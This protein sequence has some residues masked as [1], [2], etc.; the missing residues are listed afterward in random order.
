ML[1]ND[2]LLNGSWCLKELY[3]AVTPACQQGELSYSDY[4]VLH[5][6][7]KRGLSDFEG[8]NFRE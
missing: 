3:L 4:S 2:S 8:D 1:L 5:L 7:L 6:A